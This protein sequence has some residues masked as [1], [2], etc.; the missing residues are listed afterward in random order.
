MLNESYPKVNKILAEDSRNGAQSSASR[1]GRSPRINVN[2]EPRGQGEFLWALT[3][4]MEKGPAGSGSAHAPQFC[5]CLLQPE[6][7]AH[8]AV[9][10]RHSGQVLQGLL[11]FTR[12]PVEP[13][14]A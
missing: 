12:P 4:G 2:E 3:G 8:L 9:H 5:L 1:R 13:A 10:R 7:H 6:M 14:E 11:A